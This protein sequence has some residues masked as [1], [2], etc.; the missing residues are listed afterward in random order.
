MV[1]SFMYDGMIIDPQILTGHKRCI[2]GCVFLC[3]YVCIYGEP[4]LKIFSTITIS[5]ISTTFC[6]KSIGD[7]VTMRFIAKDID[8]RTIF[9]QSHKPTK[10]R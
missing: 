2:I 6:D 8:T 4:Q 7:E 10:Q 3:V 1:Y 5:F 9:L